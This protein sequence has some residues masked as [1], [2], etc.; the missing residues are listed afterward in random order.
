MPEITARIFHSL[1]RRAPRNVIQVL[2]SVL[3]PRGSIHLV[4]DLHARSDPPRGR[5]ARARAIRLSCRTSLVM[6]RIIPSRSVSLQVADVRLSS[7]AIALRLLFADPPAAVTVGVD[8]TGLSVKD[9]PPPF[10]SSIRN[11]G[12]RDRS[13][14]GTRSRRMSPSPNKCRLA[15]S[16]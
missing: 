8:D 12:P 14:S 16:P 1:L 6:T 11:R 15:Q 2:G 3:F 10:W 4:E 9:L 5:P 7:C 13:A